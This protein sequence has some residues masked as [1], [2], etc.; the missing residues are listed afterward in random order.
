ML[1]VT[2]NGSGQ[3]ST[4][5]STLT[6]GGHTI[7]ATYTPSGTFAASSGSTTQT[8]DATH[9]HRRGKLVPIR[10]LQPADYVHGPR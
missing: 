9:Q 4:T 3:A 6:V 2:L 7:N 10:Q 5:A 8:V 1:A